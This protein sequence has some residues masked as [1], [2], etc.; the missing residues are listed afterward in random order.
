MYIYIYM[1]FCIFNIGMLIGFVCIYI[2]IHRFIYI[3]WLQG[4]CC[5]GFCT[6]NGSGLRI[7]KR[8]LSTIHR[9]TV[10]NPGLAM[11]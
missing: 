10:T 3:Y 9:L 1:Y 2:Y 11:G 7:D 4:V 5:V 8:N 6:L